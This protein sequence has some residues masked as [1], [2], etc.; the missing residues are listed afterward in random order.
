MDIPEST[1]TAA[2]LGL[3]CILVLALLVARVITPVERRLVTSVAFLLAGVF[4]V[5]QPTAGA[6]AQIV[7]VTLWA[8]GLAVFT[9]DTLRWSRAAASP[10]GPLAVLLLLPP[11]F[12]GAVLVGGVVIGLLR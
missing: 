7:G 1:F 5:A 6:V 12:F 2:T 9:R 11:A 3:L 8:A 4:F 10:Y